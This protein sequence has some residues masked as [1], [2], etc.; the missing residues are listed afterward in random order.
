MRLKNKYNCIIIDDDELDRLVIESHVRQYP[1]IHILGTF[2]SAGEAL[3][4]VRT[5]D[6]DILFSDIDMPDTTGI[7]LRKQWMDI[8]VCIFVTSYP[9]YAAESFE[10]SAFDFIVKPISEERFQAVMAR[11]EAYFEIRQKAD[12]LDYSLG[13]DT[14]FIKDG[15]QQIKLP[16]H[17]IMYLEALK[18]YT[19]VVTPEKKYCVLSSLG[20]LLKENDFQSFIRIHR[21]FAVQK[22]FIDVI[23]AQQVVIHDIKLPIGRNYKAGLTQI[24]QR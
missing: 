11:C 14:I 3:R 17:Q 2:T 10:V 8:P 20:N 5:D 1:F 22:N 12:L 24:M 21:S 16:L 15:H 6:I 18:D 19:S 13:K 4:S 7:E 9:D 23:S